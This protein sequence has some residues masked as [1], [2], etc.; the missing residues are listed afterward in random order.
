MDNRDSNL[1]ER[2]TPAQDQASKQTARRNKK[3]YEK[4]AF[5]YRA[6]LEALAG[7]CT[8]V[9]PGKPSGVCGSAFS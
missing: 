7:V 8:P 4:P 2:Q 5:V 1:A 6:P 3:P 9:P